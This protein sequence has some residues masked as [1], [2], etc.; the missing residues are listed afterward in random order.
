MRDLLKN[1][2]FKIKAKNKRQ[3]FLPNDILF[4]EIGI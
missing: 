2:V 3:K 4:D 1:R